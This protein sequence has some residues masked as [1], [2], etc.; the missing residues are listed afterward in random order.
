MEE[1]FKLRLEDG[2]PIKGNFLEAGGTGRLKFNMLDWDLDGIMD[3]IVGTPRH[4]SVPNPEN[5]LP[6]TYREEGKPGSTVLFLKNV[7]TDAAPIY[8]FPKLLRYKGEPMFLGQHSCAPTPWYNNDSNG[9][10]L[11]VGRENGMFYFFDRK[12]ISW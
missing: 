5:G 1:G 10:S 3:L 2:Q 12:F 8:Q 9:P 4:A 11:V 7:G 6:W